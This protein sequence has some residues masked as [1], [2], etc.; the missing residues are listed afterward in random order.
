MQYLLLR[1]GKYL[2][3]DLCI[4]KSVVHGTAIPNYSMAY[5]E[6][7]AMNIYTPN[8]RFCE[9]P[10]CEEP[11]VGKSHWVRFCCKSHQA[12]YAGKKSKGALDRP[13]PT[14]VEQ[15]ATRR[16]HSAKYRNG[17]KLNIPHWVNDKDIKAIYERA[18]KLSEETGIRYEVDHID[19]IKHNLVCGLHCPENLQVIPMTENR[20]KK[21]HWTPYEIHYRYIKT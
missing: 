6:H 2:S 16:H 11:L 3:G 12:R 9:L 7:T 14:I 1:C 17:Q 18:A 5:K 10:G 8:T 20:A 15:Q 13:T 19:P 4:N 21:N